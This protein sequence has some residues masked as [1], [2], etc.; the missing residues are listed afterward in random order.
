VV[1][2]GDDELGEDDLPEYLLDKLETAPQ[3]NSLEAMAGQPLEEVE[4]QHIVRTLELVDGN[5]EK[6]AEL[7]GIGERTLYRKIEKYDLR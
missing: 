7:L 6:A 4:K 5:R 2:T 3:E 1:V